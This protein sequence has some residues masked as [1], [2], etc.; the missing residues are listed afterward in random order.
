MQNRNTQSLF[1]I[2]HSSRPV[3][4]R[5]TENVLPVMPASAALSVVKTS[6]VRGQQHYTLQVYLWRPCG[7]GTVTS[8][9]VALA[10]G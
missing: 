9:L 1:R 4:E 2:R 3:A 8:S 5:S 6:L 10:G 7:L